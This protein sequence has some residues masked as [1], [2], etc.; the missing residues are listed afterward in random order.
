[1]FTLINTPNFIYFL[2]VFFYWD[3]KIGN[4]CPKISILLKKIIRM[5]CF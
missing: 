5:N 3:S 4:K 2:N 1:M